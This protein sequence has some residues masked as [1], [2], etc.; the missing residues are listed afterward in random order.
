[1]VA[2]G[3]SHYMHTLTTENDTLFNLSTLTRLG[4]G[5]PN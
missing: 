1:M 5:W 2:G 3:W 4:L